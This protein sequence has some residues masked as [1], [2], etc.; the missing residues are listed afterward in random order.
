MARIFGIVKSLDL[1]LFRG[2]FL[3]AEGHTICGFHDCLSR[4]P[5]DNLS[6]LKS[7]GGLGRK[8]DGSLDPETSLCNDRLK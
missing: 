6:D 2:N 7:T 1:Y 3:L 8:G 4:L 5:W